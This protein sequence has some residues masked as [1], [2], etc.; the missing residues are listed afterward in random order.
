MA[1][2]KRL[3]RAKGEGS[4]IRRKD[5]RWQASRNIKMLGGITKRLYA[6]GKTAQEALAKLNEAADRA[7]SQNP[8]TDR[9]NTVEKYLDYWLQNIVLFT[10]RPKTY[11]NYELMCRRYLK[12][13]I[14]KIRLDTLTVPM[15][16][17]FFKDMLEKGHSVRK[18]QMMRTTLSGA[19]TSAMREEILGR[20]VA[21]LV[22]L[23]EWNRKEIVPWSK[24]EAHQFL[25]TAKD[26]ELY[27]AFLML[28]YYGLR[29]GEVIALQWKDIDFERE[30]LH[31]RRQL[32]HVGGQLVVS[33]VKT[34]AGERTIPLT[35]TISEALVDHQLRFMTKRILNKQMT[36]WSDAEDRALVFQTANNHPIEPNN[37]ARS[38]HR[39]CKANNIRRISVHHVRHTTATLLKDLGV[40]ARDVQIILGHASPWTT[41]QVYTHYGQDI[42]REALQKLDDVLQPPKLD[43]GEWDDEDDEAG[44]DAVAAS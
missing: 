22:R 14:G 35:E 24:D 13:G 29:R 11:E 33:P 1:H 37:F 27:P 2:N 19:L 21:R 38:F 23:P 5:G 12:P 9:Y 6:Y 28:V 8:T 17:A 40:P 39:I 25:H 20:N 36:T 41:T 10:K 26:H 32:Q 7:K 34:N 43:E 18:V 30:A 44:T 4:I 31:I 3:R 15:L 16:Q 42:M